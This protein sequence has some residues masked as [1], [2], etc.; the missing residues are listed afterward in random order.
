MFWVDG[1]GFSTFG[2]IKTWDVFSESYGK[3]I[4]SLGKNYYIIFHFDEQ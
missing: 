2:H 4:L 3:N 1:Y